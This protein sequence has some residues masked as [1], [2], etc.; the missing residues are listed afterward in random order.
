MKETSDRS[1]KKDRM[2]GDEWEDWTGDLDESMAYN[3]TARL[4]TIFASA[5]LIIL[6]VCIGFILYMIEPR[7]ALLHPVWVIAARVVTVVI[8]LST[9][10]LSVLII[11]SV[12][13]GRNFLVNTRLGQ[14]LASSI[15]PVARAIARQMGISRD[16]FGNSF[17]AFSNA[18]VRAR[19]KPV[20]GKT[21]VLIP[22]CLNAE[23]KKEV[24]ALCEQAGLGVFSATGGGQARQIIRKEHPDAVI[25]VACERDLV[26]GIRD[27]APKIPTLGVANK[28]PE[29]PCKNTVIELDELKKA[30]KILTGAAL[31]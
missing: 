22:R 26:S 18:I 14:I 2:L 3:E 29:G 20:K 10:T 28:R 31:E 16:R 24:R 4:F 30:I 15:L 5:A 23:T 12:F 13:T 27:V 11:T 17:V 19:K 25:G 7:L 8:T 9:V 6:L 21:I 1:K